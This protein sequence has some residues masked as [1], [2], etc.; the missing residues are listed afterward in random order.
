MSEKTKMTYEQ[1][2]Q[3]KASQHEVLAALKAGTV[4]LEDVS[5]YLATLSG[6][7]NGNGV[8][9]KVSDKGCVHFRGLKGTNVRF[10]LAL[11]VEALDWL[12]SHREKIER[13]I[14]DNQAEINRRSEESR[15]ERSAA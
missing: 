5:R 14:K 12:F 2:V 15:A 6:G 4:E 3:A 1:L 9:M 8:R 10:G 7:T 13:F 11:R